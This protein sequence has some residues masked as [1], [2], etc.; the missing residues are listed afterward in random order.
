MINIEEPVYDVAA[1]GGCCQ[2][3][4]TQAVSRVHIVELKPLE[5][6]AQLA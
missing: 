2:T 4:R 1:V 3:A 5:A 6:A